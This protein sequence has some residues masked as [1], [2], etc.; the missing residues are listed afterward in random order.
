M[1][2]HVK[3]YCY[4]IHVGINLKMNYCRMD[5]SKTNLGSFQVKECEKKI[6]I[7]KPS[8]Q[9]ETSTPLVKTKSNTAF[10]ITLDLI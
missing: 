10:V 6:S 7:L 5:N 3:T 1:Y 4:C 2:R 9:K 8:T